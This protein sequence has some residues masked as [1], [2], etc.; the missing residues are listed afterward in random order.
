M[1]ALAEIFGDDSVLQF[2]GGTLGHP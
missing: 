2:S 1:P